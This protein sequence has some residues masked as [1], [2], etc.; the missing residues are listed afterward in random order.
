MTHYIYR[1]QPTRLEMLSTGPSDE[2]VQAVAD[3]FAYLQRLASQ[4]QLFMAGRS[5][6]ADDRAFGIAVFAAASAQ[7]AQAVLD[8]DPA[9]VRGVMRGEVYAFEVAL[10][11]GNPLAASG[12]A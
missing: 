12:E 1:V 9:V 10:W 5:L 3:H 4:G 11:S 2:E 7:D 6:L 8:N